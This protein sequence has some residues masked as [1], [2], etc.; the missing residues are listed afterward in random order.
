MVMT[1]GSGWAFQ[2]RNTGSPT[3]SAGAGLVAPYWV[4]LVRSGTTISAFR[5]VDG[6]GWSQSGGNMTIALTDPVQVGFAA[7]SN[8]A[9]SP[10]VRA[11][12]DN[13]SGFPA[14]NDAPQ[15]NPGTAPEAVSG[16]PAA[17]AASASDDARPS[18]SALDLTWSL[19]SGPGTATFANAKSA[20][21]SVTF[22]T[23]GSYVVRLAAS[24]GSATVFQDMTVAVTSSQTPFEQWSG[25]HGLSGGSAADLADPDADGVPNLVEYALGGNPG[26]AGSAPRVQVT[27]PTPSVPRLRMEI[28]R[29]ADPSLTY[30]IWASDDLV[31]WGAAPVWTSTGPANAAGNATFTDSADLSLRPKRFLR[32][33]V[34]RD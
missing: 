34:T 12:F 9:T 32:L 3:S 7:S 19:V 26:S 2:T 15:V 10:Q 20:A 31:N 17:L 18:G 5:S 23:A 33:K 6:I 28:P 8:S 14:G 27:V 16:S 22:S 25:Q 13:I 4:R 11:V 30:E 1:P 24:D 21:T 29:V